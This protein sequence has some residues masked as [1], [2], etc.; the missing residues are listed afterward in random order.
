[1]QRILS[2]LVAAA[3]TLGGFVARGAGDDK[4]ADLLAKAR[5]VIGGEKQ[6]A[7]VQ[8]LSCTG[9]VQRL[10]GDRQMSGEL[11]LELQ[12]PD[13]MLRTESISPM[14][15]GALVVTE[16]GVNGDM[17]LRAARTLNTPPGMIIRTPPAPAPGSDAEAQ[18]L[19]NARA[20]LSRLALGLLLG[21]P[22][23]GPLEFAYG[24]EAESADGAADVIDAKGTGNFASRLFFDKQTHRLLMIAYRG[25]SPRMVVRTQRMPGA[26][27]SGRNEH[28]D[29]AG[30][31]P[32]VVD[33]TMYF[34]DYRSVDG[35]LLPHHISR[36]VDGETAEEWTF[37]S[38][39][40]N[41]AF[42]PAT[43]AQK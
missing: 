43:F 35:L 40:V 33:I 41:P 3:M 2:Y 29:P 19:R 13:K 10:L 9:T 24:G 39:R 31:P 23:A 34:D 32:D 28:A 12:L 20:E 7:K 4:A 25:A 5:A 18:A 42:K 17:L 27:A 37:S 15:D 6:I 16:Q 22:G 14:N 11:T 26:P 8:G 38:V 36:S 1:M 21:P 30:P